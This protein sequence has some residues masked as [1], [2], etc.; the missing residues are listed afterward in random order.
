MTRNPSRYPP[1]HF[2]SVQ[3]GVGTL[4]GLF[5]ALPSYGAGDPSQGKVLAQTCTGCH[6]VQNYDNV[7]PTYHVPKLGGQSADYLASALTAYQAGKRT[8]STMQ[9]NVAGLSPRDIEDIVAYFSSL[10]TANVK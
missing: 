7:Y 5:L 6:G 1:R 2:G 9:A 8:H 4:I 10:E 3:L